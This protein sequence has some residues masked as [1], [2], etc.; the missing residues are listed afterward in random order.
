MGRPQSPPWFWRE[1]LVALRSKSSCEGVPDEMAAAQVAQVNLI[2][3]WH[4]HE[5]PRDRMRALGLQSRARP[6]RV[7]DGGSARR[8]G[9]RRDI[10]EARTGGWGPRR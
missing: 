3:R 10:D 8:P 5:V 2:G 9:R 6:C 4:A 1:T 7:P